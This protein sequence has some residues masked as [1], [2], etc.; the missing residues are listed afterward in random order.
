M[1]L[2]VIEHGLVIRNLDVVGVPVDVERDPEGDV[3][4]DEV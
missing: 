3:T 4:V 1:I 2:H